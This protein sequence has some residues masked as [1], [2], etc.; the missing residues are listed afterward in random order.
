MNVSLRSSAEVGLLMKK[1]KVIYQKDAS[2]EVFPEL[3]FLP[4]QNQ[5]LMLTLKINLK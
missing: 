5:G 4:N 1:E 3:T 2:I